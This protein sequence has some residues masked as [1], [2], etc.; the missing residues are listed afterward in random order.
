MQKSIAF[1]YII[2][3]KWEKKVIEKDPHVDI[4]SSENYWIT[5]NQVK[6]YIKLTW[7]KLWNLLKGKNMVSHPVEGSVY[8]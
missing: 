3:S 1:L 7:N 5:M 8:F 6:K 2:N 4:N